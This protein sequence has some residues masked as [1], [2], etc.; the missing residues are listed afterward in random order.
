MLRREF[1]KMSGLGLIAYPVLKWGRLFQPVRPG[2]ANPALDPRF[3]LSQPL[4]LQ[5]E[6][7]GALP[8]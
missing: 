3:S 4:R 8:G 5:D 1:C 6:F 2:Q 7:P